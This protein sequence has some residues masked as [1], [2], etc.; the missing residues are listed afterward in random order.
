[1][2]DLDPINKKI[3]DVYKYIKDLGYEVQIE[4]NFYN[5]KIKEIRSENLILIEVVRENK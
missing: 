4:S 1:M 5:P 3:Y 2:E